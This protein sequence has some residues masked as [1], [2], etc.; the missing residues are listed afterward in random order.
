MRNTTGGKKYKSQKKNEYTN[1]KE[2]VTRNENERYGIVER[3]KGGSHFDIK[4]LDINRFIYDEILPCYLRGSMRGRRKNSNYIT[5]GSVVL[6]SIRDYQTDKG[7][8]I[9]VYS[10]NQIHSLI[11]MSHIPHSDQYISSQY[12][13]ETTD[14]EK[15]NNNSINYS[16]LYESINQ[17]DSTISDNIKTKDNINSNIT[18]DF[19]NYDN[20]DINWDDI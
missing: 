17:Q 4:L 19:K 10:E 12:I 1:K 11:K 7:D 15:I 14:T 8:I 20:D 9:Y 2:L 3:N 13:S 18:D 16:D 5:K 6:I